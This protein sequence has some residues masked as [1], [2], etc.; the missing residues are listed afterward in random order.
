MGMGCKA[1]FST[2]T[3]V[4]PAGDEHPPRGGPSRVELLQADVA[5][6]AQC[7][8]AFQHVQLFEQRHP[9]NPGKMDLQYQ[10]R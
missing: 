9:L 10:A 7:G 4:P 2:E 3:Y 8:K 6:E 1:T 5:T